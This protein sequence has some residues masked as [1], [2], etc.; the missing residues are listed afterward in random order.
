M[1]WGVVLL[2]RPVHSRPFVFKNAFLAYPQPRAF[3][4][5]EESLQMIGK[6]LAGQWNTTRSNALTWLAGHTGHFTVSCDI[7]QGHR[8]PAENL[9][10]PRHCCCCPQL[11]IL[12]VWAY[13]AI[14]MFV[15]PLSLAQLQAAWIKCMGLFFSLRLPSH[16]N[17]FLCQVYY[18]LIS[19]MKFK[20]IYIY[21]R[22]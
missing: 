16:L 20:Y 7:F 1:L 18:V 13:L 15:F 22:D 21:E 14:W 19:G 2:C 10:V 5:A 17:S 3:C 4:E 12:Q 11:L 6:T 9:P 8:L